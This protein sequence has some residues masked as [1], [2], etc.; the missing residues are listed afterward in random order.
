VWHDVTTVDTRGEVLPF[1]DITLLA[2]EHGA[3]PHLAQSW[4]GVTAGLPR[5]DPDGPDLGGPRV[6][7]G[8]QYVG[9]QAFRQTRLEYPRPLEA[10]PPGLTGPHVRTIEP[11][12]DISLRAFFEPTLVPHA[13]SD[14]RGVATLDID[15]DRTIVR[16]GDQSLAS[17][18]FASLASTSDIPVVEALAGWLVR[19]IDLWLV[20]SS[21]G[22]ITGAT[23]LLPGTSTSA[24]VT[25]A[26]S[27][28]LVAR[29][30][31]SNGSRLHDV[32]AIGDDLALDTRVTLDT[33]PLGPAAF[34]IITD[35]P[36]DGRSLKI[37]VRAPDHE[38]TT[39]R[40]TPGASA[41]VDLVDVELVPRPRR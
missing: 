36:G 11:P 29:V 28:L 27:P 2:A 20:A 26:P 30:T 31:D 3:R 15:A 23:R 10:P 4:Q 32:Q 35:H 12:V 14:A 7:S 22:H 40:W 41:Q 37:T 17:V 16:V 19:E 6:V 24:V 18:P 1:T 33:E 9:T 5:D 38:Q 8:F 21:A 25:L 39:F 13:Q 34:V